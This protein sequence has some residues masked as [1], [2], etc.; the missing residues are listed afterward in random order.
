MSMTVAMDV[1][2]C[3][4]RYIVFE[5]AVM[6]VMEVLVVH[7]VFVLEAEEAHCLYAWMLK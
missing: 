3:Q 6:V 7:L 1:P 2:L 5:V 4:L